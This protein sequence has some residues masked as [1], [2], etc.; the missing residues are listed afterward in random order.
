M[1]YLARWNGESWRAFP[2]GVDGIVLGLTAMADQLVV[3]GGFTRTGTV[4]SSRIAFWEDPLLGALEFPRITA[5]ATTIRTL[6]ISNPYGQSVRI[7]GISFA[8][9][10]FGIQQ[11][12]VDSVSRG[13]ELPPGE[14]VRTSVGFYPMDGGVASEEIMLTMAPFTSR[15]VILLSGD[16]RRISMAW[17]SS[18]QYA[19]R[20]IAVNDSVRVQIA[21]G[22]SVE[23]DS[24]VL[25]Y[26]QGG[27]RKYFHRVM[28]RIL[29]DPRNDQYQQFVPDSIARGRGE[30]FLVRA[31]NG[32]AVAD[33][34]SIPE[35]VHLRTRIENLIFPGSQLAGA[36]QLVSFPVSLG[37]HHVQ[38][39]LGDNLG[40]PDARSWRMFAYHPDSTSQYR[41]MPAYCDS[42]K[43]GEAYWLVTRDPVWIDTGPEQSISTPCDSPFLVPLAPGW[44][45]VGNP[46]NFNV[47]WDSVRVDTAS[48]TDPQAVGVPVFAQDVVEP[49]VAWDA[50]TRQ[51]RQDAGLLVPFAGY[52][53]RNRESFD[54]RL[55]IPPEEA[56]APLEMTGATA[57]TSEGWQLRLE[58]ACGQLRDDGGVVGMHPDASDSYDRLDRSQPPLGPGWGLSLYFP[59]PEW[60]SAGGAYEIDI[61]REVTWDA[62]GGLPLAL[63]DGDEPTIAGAVWRFDVVGTLPG[64]GA[65]D[66]P[67]SPWQENNE[68]AI[69]WIGLEGL[70]PSLQAVLLDRTTCRETPLASSPSYRFAC[71]RLEFVRSPEECRFAL[72]VGTEE[73]IHGRESEIWSSSGTTRLLP[74]RPNPISSPVRLRYDLA[75]PV[76]VGI[77]IYNVTGALVRQLP[78]DVGQAG[79]HEIVWDLNDRSG[80]PLPSGVYFVSLSDGVR[81]Q[82]T[83]VVVVR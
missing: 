42:L 8:G 6:R 83:R 29:D 3:G 56:P 35:P 15:K 19:S 47:A 53:V 39:V 49:P 82:A 44:N 79:R 22:D 50:S 34:G 17:A 10:E 36:Y 33:L 75:A 66:A 27:A 18:L 62:G 74:V 7:G 80:T 77:S 13:L 28:P 58:A 26:R 63:P 48:A 81:R 24:L 9:S 57:K 69:T 40:L 21:M 55:R 38:T 67:D 78:G 12:F 4:A 5:G 68:I 37:S 11:S 41:E 71:S 2:G 23:V 31:Y 70:P 46:F 64:V 1:S 59:H 65:L 60:G 54:L 16:A 43:Q 30:D 72:V 73:F 20:T 45:L 32:R 25:W 61:R 51:Y 76:S 52:W 14:S